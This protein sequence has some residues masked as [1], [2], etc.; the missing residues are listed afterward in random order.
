MA[1]FPTQP[2]Q[3]T[4]LQQLGVESVGLGPSMFARYGDTRGMGTCASTRRAHQRANQKP[5]RP[6]SN[7]SAIRVILEAALTASSRQRS[8]SPSSL[9]AL[10]SSFLHG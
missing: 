7:A 1:P 8:S 2:S 6:A 9:S 3:E 10:G 4:P 5:S